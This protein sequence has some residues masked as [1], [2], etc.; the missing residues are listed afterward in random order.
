MSS[1]ILNI[2]GGPKLVVSNVASGP[3]DAKKRREWDYLLFLSSDL[4][5][6]YF[7]KMVEVDWFNYVEFEKY[8]PTRQ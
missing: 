2:S 4:K 8:E 7:L 3:P 5:A 1:I 6:Y